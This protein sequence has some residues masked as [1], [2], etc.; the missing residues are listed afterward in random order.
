MIDSE[1]LYIY[2]YIYIYIYWVVVSFIIG[3]CKEKSVLL[4]PLESL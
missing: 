2:I 4:V 1:N 3:I